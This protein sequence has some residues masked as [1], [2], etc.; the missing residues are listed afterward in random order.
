MHAQLLYQRPSGVWNAY[1]YDSCIKKTPWDHSKRVGE[2]PTRLLILAEVGITGP[3]WFST[4]VICIM[5]SKQT[6]KKEEV[7]NNEPTID[8]GTVI[9][10]DVVHQYIEW[11]NHKFTII[12]TV[13]N[14]NWKLKA[15]KIR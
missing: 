10:E 15:E 7:E 5:L 3:Q 14:C 6:Q 9:T 1:M 2:S 8:I 13:Y 4:A 11:R 12:M